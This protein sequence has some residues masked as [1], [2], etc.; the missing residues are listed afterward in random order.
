MNRAFILP[1]ALPVALVSAALLLSV[2]AQAAPR[3]LNQIKA[4][5]T[6]K[7][8]TE[9]ALSSLQLLRGQGPDG[10]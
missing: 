3:T 8:G 1:T 7:L 2:T 5:G 10:L 6:L 4:A 9:A